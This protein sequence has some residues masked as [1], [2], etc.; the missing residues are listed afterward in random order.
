MPLI[1]RLLTWC[2]G[3]IDDLYVSMDIKWNVIHLEKPIQ[4]LYLNFRVKVLFT[5]WKESLGPHGF[6]EK[7]WLLAKVLVFT[8]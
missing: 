3:N 8:S 2:L 6:Q 7:C 1:P 4:T 5:V